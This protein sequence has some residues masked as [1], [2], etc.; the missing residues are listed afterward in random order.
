MTSLVLFKHCFT[1]DY[2]FDFNFAP[3]N[4]SNSSL[5]YDLPDTD[6]PAYSKKSDTTKIG[7]IELGLP[8][9]I[10]LVSECDCE[11]ACDCTSDNDTENL[12]LTNSIT[13]SPS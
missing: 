7:D 4:S 10:S 8:S 12:S 5:Q 1:N 11:C 6:L 2:D 13:T 3:L 9:Y